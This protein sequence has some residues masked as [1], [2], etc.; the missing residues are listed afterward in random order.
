MQ[1]Q[2]EVIKAFVQ[3][4]SELSSVKTDSVN[5]FFKAKYESLEAV[6]NTLRPVLRKNELAFSQCGTVL[7][8]VMNLS[9]Y[10]YHTSG[11]ELAMGCVTVPAAKEHDPQAL[12]SA[13]TLMRRAQL[14]A[15]F[16]LGVEDDDGN[17][18]SQPTTQAPVKNY[19]PRPQTAEDS[20][21]NFT[22]P[23]EMQD[24]V[25]MDMPAF[26]E[27]VESQT[28]NKMD[29]TLETYVPTFGKFKGV[30]LK[31]IPPQDIRGYIQ[32]LTKG[33]PPKGAAKAFV[34]NASAYLKQFESAPS[35]LAGTLFERKK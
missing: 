6:V 7:N 5:P 10:L 9:L 2:T 15:A 24:Q 26:D 25:P 8:G 28:T 32:F 34:E 27:I 22:H 14:L 3:A 4:Q 29:P 19:A 21:S 18:A 12:K 17:V 33:D 13:M 30:A 20:E 16:G 31:D 1:T 11:Q 35:P 23:S